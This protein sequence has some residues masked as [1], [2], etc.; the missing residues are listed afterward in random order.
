MNRWT[1]INLML[2]V[3]VAGL[4]GLHLWPTTPTQP[5]WPTS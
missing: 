1:R 4:L 5:T 2:A 3:L